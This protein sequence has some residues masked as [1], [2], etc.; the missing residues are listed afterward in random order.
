[1]RTAVV[2]RAPFI[3]SI[4]TVGSVAADERRLHHVH[5]KIDGWVE[6]LNVNATGQKVRRG[7]PLLSLYSPEL[8]AS[9]E[10]YLLALRSR[11]GEA[12]GTL[13]E[14]SRTGS[15]LVDS[16][17]RRLLLFDMTPDQIESLERTGDYD[18]VKGY[19]PGVDAT[20]ELSLE[21]FE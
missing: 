11:R 19:L 15:D 8:V 12:A 17:R 13:P 20:R 1:V 14:A 2:K 21:A 7:E 5:T 3:R 16:A 9:Q 4:R 10:E 18:Q 6:T